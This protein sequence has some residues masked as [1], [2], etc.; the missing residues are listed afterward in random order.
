MKLIKKI[1]NLWKNN[2]EKSSEEYI[3]REDFKKSLKEYSKDIMAI[4]QSPV[5]NFQEKDLE[6]AMIVQNFHIQKK[7]VH[8]TDS[9]RNA[10]WILAL[11]TTIF[12]WVTIKDSPN[13]NEIL[14]T[15]SQI[16][17][18]ILYIF[19]FLIAFVLIKKIALF[20]YN[21]FKKK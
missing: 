6:K 11:A 19:M 16:V 13:S 12:A 15:L 1:Q 20:L 7:L 10:T 8:A 18:V 3:E 2:Q 9:L 14:T 21:S 17:I 5:F 4:F